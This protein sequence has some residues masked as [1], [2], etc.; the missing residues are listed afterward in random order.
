MLNEKEYKK[1]YYLKNKEKILERTKLNYLKNKDAKKKRSKEYCSTKS[2]RITRYLS[3]A[4]LRAKEKNLDFDLDLDFLRSIA[5]DKCPVFGFDLGWQNWG[6]NGGVASYDS[7]SLDRIDSNKGYTK[8]NVQWVSWKANHIKNNS[9][10]DDLIAVAK[11]MKNIER[12]RDDK[13]KSETEVDCDNTRKH[14]T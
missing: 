1:Q 5:P 10:A 7:P 8:D 3:E 12:M 9:T 13:P 2:G 11:W 14:P 4:K 6:S